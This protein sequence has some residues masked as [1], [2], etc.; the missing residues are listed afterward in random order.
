MPRLLIVAETDGSH[1]LPATLPCITFAQKW[2]GVTSGEF[3]I[4]VAGGIS[5]ESGSDC[6][7]NY[8][9][10]R[11]LKLIST[12]FEHPVAE[13]IA[14]AIVTAFNTSGATSICAASTTFGRDVMPRVAALLDL[15]MISDL[16][17]VAGSSDELI[18]KRPMYAGNLIASVAVTGNDTVITVRGTAFGKPETTEADSDIVA[19][20]YEP[21]AESRTKW[22]SIESADQSR[23]ELTSARVVVSGGRPLKDA[24]TFERVIGGLADA[25][26]GAVGA[27]RAAV[28]SGIA[29][30]ELQV[31]QTG[32]VVAPELYIA[33]GISGSIQHIAGMK[34]SKIIVSI[35]TDPEAPITEIADYALVADLH[36]AVPE[37]TAKLSG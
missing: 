8:G 1:I 17:D 37:L 7:K 31:G 36:Q 10:N 35:N 23:P 11:I 12:D 5:V 6:L 13:T 22:I 3:D 21:A 16:L 27:T 25:L 9:A 26:G 18:Y 34:D 2:A 28:D 32:K 14:A 30:N 20:D 29:P 33:A 24:A 15:P 4:L 19:L